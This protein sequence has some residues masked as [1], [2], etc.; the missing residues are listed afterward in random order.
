MKSSTKKIISVVCIL[1]LIVGVFAA[2]KNKEEDG[3][4]V[5]VSTDENGSLYYT[6]PTKEVDG[7]EYGGETHFVKPD[8]TNRHG[9]YV[10]HPDN[11]SAPYTTDSKGNVGPV[12]DST[13]APSGSGSQSGSGTTAPSTTKQGSDGKTTTS[14][15][16]TTASGQTT[17]ATEPTE[18]TSIEYDPIDLVDSNGLSNDGVVDAW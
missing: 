15:S 1:L 13:T 14:G 18:T 2:C 5:S 9:E 4:R 7:I 10:I 6:D 3:T 8:E 17:A 11:T 12:E 16:G